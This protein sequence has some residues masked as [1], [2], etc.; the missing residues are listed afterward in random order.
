[1]H[2]FGSNIGPQLWKMI[3]GEKPT[4]YSLS[5]SALDAI[6]RSLDAASQSLPTVFDGHMIGDYYP[7]H[8]KIEQRTY[9]N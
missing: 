9:W 8:T 6:H 1:M 3:Q 5:T 2:L 7:V 4:T